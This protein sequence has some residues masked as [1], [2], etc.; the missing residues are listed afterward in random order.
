M[1]FVQALAIANMFQVTWLIDLTVFIIFF[2]L[3]LLR[4]MIDLFIYFP[5]ED[6]YAV[7]VVF[8]QPD[9]YTG[10]LV[11]L[12]PSALDN[13]IIDICQNKMKGNEYWLKINRGM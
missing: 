6:W 11:F 3:H 13:N 8:L 9:W 4:E 5:L 7:K 12:Q 2:S 10:K 1:F